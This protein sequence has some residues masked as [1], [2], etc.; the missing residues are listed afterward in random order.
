M[1]QAPPEKRAEWARRAAEKGGIVPQ[2][3]EVFP[4]RV[5]IQCGQC[6]HGYKRPLIMNQNDPIFACPQCQARNWIP[7]TYDLK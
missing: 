1:N 6:R 7:I 2:F 3:F 4:S 5:E